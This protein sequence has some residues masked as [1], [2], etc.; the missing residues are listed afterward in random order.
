MHTK[1]VHIFMYIHIYMCLNK[2]DL[3]KYTSSSSSLSSSVG[4]RNWCLILKPLIYIFVCTCMYMRTKDI[5]I[6]LYVCMHICIHMLIQV[7]I[8]IT[9]R[10]WKKLVFDHQAVSV[11]LYKY[12]C[13]YVCI[14]KMYTYLCVHLFMMK[15]SPS[16]SSSSLSSSSSSL[17]SPSVGGRNSYPIP[18]PRVIIGV[19]PH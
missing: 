3:F 16:S 6:C 14:Q 1:D 5:H 17:S 13:I 10:W 11:C 2:H 8:I 19:S 15:M 18:R 12:V 4:G 9:Q 7:N